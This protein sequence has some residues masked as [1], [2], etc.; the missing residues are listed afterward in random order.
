MKYVKI[1]LFLIKKMKSDKLIIKQKEKGI[2][3]K[4]KSK[5]ILKNVLDNL[6]EKKLLYIIKYNKNIK[7][8]LYIKINDY[9]K[10]H[11]LIEIEIKPDNNKY[12]KFISFIKD[13]NYYHIYFNNNKEE[14]KRNYINENENVHIIKIIIDHQVISFK[15][16]FSDCECIESINFKK[17]Y[18]GDINNM[19]HM[20]YRCSSLK[21]LNLNNFNT[22]NVKH[23][24]GMFLGCSNDLIMKIKIRYKNIR[25]EAYY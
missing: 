1:K 6:E 21:E 10:Y 9:K 23:M 25:G 15:H 16:L 3:E 4:I 8:R 20:F 24:S 14:I 13:K 12:G 2:L 22:D 18:R 11:E 19:S 7:K 5:Y 17:F